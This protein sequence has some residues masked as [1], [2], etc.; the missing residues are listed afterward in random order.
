[1]RSAQDIFGAPSVFNYYSPG[2]RIAGL[3]QGGVPITNLIGPEFQ[4]FTSVT[5]LERANFIAAVLGGYYSNEVS[6]DI[7]PFT[8]LAASPSALVDYCSLVFMAGRMSLEMRT[9]LIAAVSD[10]DREGRPITILGG[11]SNIL[12]TETFDGDVVRVAT[13][14]VDN[15]PTVCAGAWV[16]VQAGHSWDDLVA[17]AVTSGWLGQ[18]ERSQRRPAAAGSIRGR[19]SS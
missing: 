18:W 6:F 3:S 16:T 1:M 14:G 13:S 8:S 2:Y 7:T 9:E 5:S 19:I 10:A 12:F 15:D 17:T 4:I 11:G